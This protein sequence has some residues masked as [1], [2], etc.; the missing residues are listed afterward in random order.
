MNQPCPTLSQIV[1]LDYWQVICVPLSSGQR[2][3]LKNGTCCRSAQLR[4]QYL[5][6]LLVPLLNIIVGD[7]GGAGAAAAGVVRMII[8]WRGRLPVFH[9]LEHIPCLCH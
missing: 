9:A 2:I 4:L 1:H 8:V 6:V 7:G 3:A 5:A